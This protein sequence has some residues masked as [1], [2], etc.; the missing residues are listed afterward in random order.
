MCGR[1]SRTSQL[2]LRLY[3]DLSAGDWSMILV[4]DGGKKSIIVNL[5]VSLYRSN[6]SYDNKLTNWTGILNIFLFIYFFPAHAHLVTEN[7]TG[8]QSGC[9]PLSTLFW[10]IAGHYA[11]WT[12]NQL[13]YIHNLWKLTSTINLYL[14]QTMHLW[15]GQTA[16]LH[17]I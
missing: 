14:L 15:P 11:T 6:T 3:R 17:D 5:A 8:C 9:Q 1:N 13:H 7:S 16:H 10:K 2:R 12:A 4:G